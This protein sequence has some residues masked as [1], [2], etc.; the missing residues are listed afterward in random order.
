MIINSFFLGS[1]CNSSEYRFDTNWNRSLY[2]L[3][4]IFFGGIIAL[5][6]F[7]SPKISD[8]FEYI[9]TEIK[10]QYRILFTKYFDKI[11]LDDAYTYLFDSCEKK[12]K[13]TDELAKN[14]SKQMQRH[15]RQI[16]NKYE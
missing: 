11:Y 5:L 14:S 16:Q 12:L 8:G 7:I 10:F 6:D 13:I 2:I 1:Y 9:T 3:F 4:L 15:N